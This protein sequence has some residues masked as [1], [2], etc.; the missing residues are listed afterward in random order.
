MTV[1]NDIMDYCCITLIGEALRSNG[2]CVYRDE[3]CYAD[4]LSLTTCA[5]PLDTS[6]E[7]TQNVVFEK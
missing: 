7:A 3:S 5:R 1:Y 6:K 2:R 4:M